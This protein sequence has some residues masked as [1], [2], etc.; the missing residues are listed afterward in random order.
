[1]ARRGGDDVYT[2]Y[3][4]FL[5]GG[6]QLGTESGLWVL[7]TYRVLL[8]IYSLCTYSYNSTIQSPV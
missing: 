5:G 1:M 6:S 3:W 8:H 2:S 7:H 4:F